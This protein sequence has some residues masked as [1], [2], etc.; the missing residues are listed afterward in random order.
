VTQ[1][2]GWAKKY[3]RFNQCAVIRHREAALAA[4][5]IQSNIKDLA[6]DCFAKF[7]PDY[8]PGLTMTATPLS[9]KTL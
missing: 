8:D 4:V 7:T 1:T 9:S 3:P 6:M 2:L 5:V